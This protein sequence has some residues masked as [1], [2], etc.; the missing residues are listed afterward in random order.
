LERR[1][2]ANCLGLILLIVVLAISGDLAIT[3]SI[4]AIGVH[5][6]LSIIELASK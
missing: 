2:G 6:A 5:I 3:A 4:I 1:G